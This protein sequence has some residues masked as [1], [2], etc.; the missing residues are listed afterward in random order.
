MHTYFVRHLAVAFGAASLV[1]LSACGSDTASDETAPVTVGPASS[2]PSAS[3]A[4][5]VSVPGLSTPLP[6]LS[7]V[8]LRDE[9][10]DLAES[11]DFAGGYPDTAILT[12]W[13]DTYPD[14]ALTV[15]PDIA[16]D[17]SIVSASSA[18]LISSEAGVGDQL[19]G[20]AVADRAG[21]C[22]GAVAV[23]DGNPDGSVRDADQPSSW[24]AL[25]GLETCSATGALAEYATV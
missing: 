14:L 1:G 9:L 15:F 4:P 18:F 20:F 24:F 2:A 3:S 19:W 10:L 7:A 25:D 21:E 13:L 6:A 12:S 8:G 22:A 17:A 16:A 23:I 11:A 5:I